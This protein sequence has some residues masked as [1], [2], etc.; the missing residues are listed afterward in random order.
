MRHIFLFT[1]LLLLASLNLFAQFKISGKIT[2]QTTGNP[3]QGA[4]VQ[5]AHTFQG[6]LTQADGSFVLE[7]APEGELDLLISYIGYRTIRER[8]TVNQD[9]NLSFKLTLVDFVMDEIVVQA[10]RVN[11]K[12]AIAFSD[13]SRED[14]QK[15][16]LGQDLPIL[17]NFTPSVVTTS[18]A[19][20]GVGYT[21]IRVRGSDATRTNI[22]VNGIPINDAESQGTFWVNMPDFASSVSGIQIQRGVGTSTNGAGAFGAT[23]NIQTNERREQ[24]YAE[25]NNS[26]GSFNTWKHTV[27]VGSG[28]IK[29]KF[30]LDARLSKVTSDGFI[31]RSFSDL[32]SVFLSGAYY[33]KKSTIRANIFTGAEQTYQAWHGVPEAKLRGDAQGIEDYIGRNLYEDYQVDEADNLRQS[34]NRTYNPYLYDKETDNYQQDHYQLFTTHTLAPNWDLNIAFHYTGGKG[35]FEQ[36]R[37]QDNLAAYDLDYIVIG[38]ETIT[39]SDLIHR[40]WLDNHFYGTVYSLHYQGAKVDF[41]FGGGWNN[42]E[43]KH[44]GE[45]IWAQYAS[46]GNIRHRYYD[47]DADKQDLNVFT[48]LYFPIFEEKLRGFADL[49]YRRVTYK[50]VGLL[51]DNAG[52]RPVNQ[53]VTHDFLNPKVGLMYDLGK[54][55]FL[56][57]SWSVGSKE[58]NRD[59]YTQAS[60]QSRPKAE[61]LL[62][63]EVGYRLQTAK[64]KMNIN[65]YW[66]NYRNQLVLTGEINNVGAYNRTNIAKSYRAGLEV[67]IGWQLTSNLHWKVNATLSQNK[68]LDFQEFVDDYDTGEQQI[69]PYKETDIAFSPNVIMGSQLEWK[70]IA[71]VS[72]A[73]LSKYV[74]EQFLDNTSNQNRKLDSYATQDVRLL[75]KFKTKLFSEVNLSLLV[76][77]ILNTEYESNGYTWGY[78]YDSQHVVENFYFPQAG[79]NF[80]VGVGLKF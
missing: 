43:G 18:D 63:Y 54:Q 34:G 24:A 72:L 14:L 65:L 48:K 42:Y 5:I 41:T 46:N 77:N 66:M 70:P 45:V 78:I 73:L 8:L 57:A 60:A 36:F 2:D 29:D 37:K 17:L 3:L 19:G 26:Y 68:V 59:D 7:K 61:M 27:M 39:Q 6:V 21:G 40:R 10:T 62:D 76:N 56:Y 53:A 47:N 80:L 12:S 49:Q 28:L 15:Q 32:K 4:S 79:I 16:N 13:V 74:S 50:Y 9:L 58:P 1:C 52:I 20:A 35:Y 75:Y 25:L 23:V 67:E 64:V 33:G 55:G 44:F 71:N 31:D 30:T 51:N 22:T 11:E 69:N 38:N